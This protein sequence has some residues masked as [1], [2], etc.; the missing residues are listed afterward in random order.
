MQNPPSPS[1][2]SALPLSG[3]VAIVTG[4]SRS[5]GASIAERLASDGANV[6]INHHGV[7]ASGHQVACDINARKGGRAV[8]IKA[9]VSTVEGRRYLLEECVQRL[10]TPHILVLNATV[11]G[12]RVLE[13]I[14][15]DY[16]DLHMNTNVKG[17]LFLAQATA[18]IMQSGLFSIIYAGS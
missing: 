5:I 16:Y 4:S 3:K 17:P 1:S 14:D 12:H 15:E 6:V 11:L 8:L 10:G 9:D 7:D 18:K 13:D 2:S